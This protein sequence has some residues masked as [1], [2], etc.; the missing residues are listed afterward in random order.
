MCSWNRK[1]RVNR[2]SF[3]AGRQYGRD[4]LRNRSLLSAVPDGTVFFFLMLSRHFRAGLS[5]AAPS[6]LESSRFL[7]HRSQGRSSSTPCRTWA[8]LI[9]FSRML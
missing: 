6:G 1:Y 5:H 3:C 2:G 4:S 7:W 8:A 9:T